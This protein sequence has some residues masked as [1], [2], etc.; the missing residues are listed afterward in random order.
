ML[1]GYNTKIIKIYIYW[2]VLQNE[3][4]LFIL[5]YRISFIIYVYIH[6]YSDF[7]IS[8]KVLFFKN[9]IYSYS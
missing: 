9:A 1:G 8:I 3:Y 4:T 6:D 7:M 2:R 5:T